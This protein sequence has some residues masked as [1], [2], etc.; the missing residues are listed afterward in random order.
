M[1]GSV[2]SFDK[3]IVTAYR[4]LQNALLSEEVEHF[5]M[6][7]ILCCRLKEKCDET[8][9]EFMMSVKNNILKSS[10]FDLI[11]AKVSNIPV[12]D[13][14]EKATINVPLKW[15]FRRHNNWKWT[16]CK[17]LSRTERRL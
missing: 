8:I 2:L 14:I 9:K 12:F 11:Q 7:S 3:Q 5:E 17:F 15:N 4:C 1:S 13:E 6:P 16:M 10:Y